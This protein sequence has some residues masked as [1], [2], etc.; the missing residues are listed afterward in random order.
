VVRSG[1]LNVAA[2]SRSGDSGSGATG[3]SGGTGASTSGTGLP[4][5]TA[6]VR[7]GTGIDQCTPSANTA[8]RTVSSGNIS[9]SVSHPS[10]ALV[11]QA[12]CNT[13]RTCADP[14]SFSLG[15]TM[16]DGVP[17]PYQKT[18]T[19]TSGGSLSV[20]DG[21]CVWN[22]GSAGFP[23]TGTVYRAGTQGESNVEAD[24]AVQT[25]GANCLPSLD[26]C[27]NVTARIRFNLPL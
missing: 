18:G 27:Q 11:C 13:T 10:S 12:G 8:Q 3:G 14:T 7:V 2:E 21:V 4:S 22:G 19:Q 9:I 23:I 20:N 16:P 24:I 25:M 1:Y 5:G 6:C 26:A 15:F 17:F